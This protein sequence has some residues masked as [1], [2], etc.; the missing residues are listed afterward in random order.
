MAVASAIVRLR[1][2]D[3][4]ALDAI[5]ALPGAVGLIE[6]RQGRHPYKA[7]WVNHEPLE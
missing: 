4:D 5:F 1:L 6:R 2:A 3:L 7:I